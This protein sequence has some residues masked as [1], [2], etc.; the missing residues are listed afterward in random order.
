[1]LERP[2][3]DIQDAQVS[4]RLGMAESDLPMSR[5]IKTKLLTILA[6]SYTDLEFPQL[7]EYIYSKRIEWNNDSAVN[8]LI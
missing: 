6:G 5:E 2:L 8:N 3:R 4:R 7:K 1:M